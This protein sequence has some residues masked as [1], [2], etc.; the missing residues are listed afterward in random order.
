MKVEFLKKFS[1]DLDD[2]KVKSVRQALIRTIE[3]M[4]SAESLDKIPQTK[5][6]KGHKTAYRTR[7]GDYRLGF[8]FEDST[9]LLARFVHRRTIYQI[10]P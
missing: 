3:L 4:E 7:V 10:F 5:K 9:I 2:L 1:R 8:F 6:L